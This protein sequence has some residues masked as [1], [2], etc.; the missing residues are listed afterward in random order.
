MNI[1]K[2]TSPSS[3]SDISAAERALLDEGLE[4]DITGDDLNLKKAELDNTD[5]DGE[6]LNEQS[7]ANDVSGDDLD[8]PGAGDDDAPEMI[9]EEDEENN[10][11]SKADTE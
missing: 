10:G 5:Q 11:Y 2:K 9:G 8:I 4:K 6:L 1:E 3:D 7:S